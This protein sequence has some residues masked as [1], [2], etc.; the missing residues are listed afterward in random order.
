MSLYRSADKGIVEAVAK[1]A[2]D[3][4]VSRASVAL[5]WLLQKPGVTARRSSAR[6]ARVTRRALW[7]R[8]SLTFTTDEI[9]T[10]EAPYAPR[11][12]A[13]HQ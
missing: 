13:A 9:K 6:R 10:L 7:R 1:V 5:A 8:L 11:R 12:I 4:G 2:A 3:R